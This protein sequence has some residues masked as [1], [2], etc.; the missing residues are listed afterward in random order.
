MAERVQI[1]LEFPVKASAAMLYN[2]LATPSGL[3]GW[4]CDDVNSR[5]DRFVFIW[6]DTEEVATLVRKR[7]DVFVQYKWEEDK[8]SNKFSFE[9]RIS[10]DDITLDAT[11]IV[12]DFVDADEVNEMK[13]LW[14]SQIHNLL[15]NIGS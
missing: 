6:G 7:Q 4:F 1:E 13:L 11:L 5:G 3:A 14:N 15:H 8:S 10:V 2:F 12:T 9:F